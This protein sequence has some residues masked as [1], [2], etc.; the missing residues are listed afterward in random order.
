MITSCRCVAIAG[1]VLVLGWLATLQSASSQTTAA[2]PAKTGP[3]SP[4]CD[5]AQFR[6]VVDVGH[7]AQAVGARSARGLPEF[8][9]NLRL[10]KEIDERLISAG[11]GKTELMVTEGPAQLS[12]TRRVART[13]SLAPDLLLSIHHDSV[14]DSFLQKWEY[15][16]SEHTFSDRF[17]GH[18]IFVSWDNPIR[19]LS[20]RFARFLGLQLR[21]QGLQYTPHYTQSFMGHRQRVLVDAEA[22]VYRYDQLRVLRE[23][24][25]PSVL[26][27][28]GSIINR[29]EELLLESADHRAL[30]SG[31]VAEAVENSCAGMPSKRM[32]QPKR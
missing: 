26:L 1:S 2:M 15:E 3:A 27:E 22:G 17:K 6:V 5:R 20:L 14:P 23:T 12:L 19:S 7:T 8:D 4:T 24:T 18:S 21:T 16:G 28:A 11:F 9:F 31:A 13:N 32:A 30:I 10:A 29:D 25:V